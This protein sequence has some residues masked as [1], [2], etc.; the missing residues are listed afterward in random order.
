MMLIKLFLQRIEENWGHFTAWLAEVIDYIES[1]NFDQK[2]IDLFCPV[3]QE[4]LNKIFLHVIDPTY[5]E[6][7]DREKLLAIHRGENSGSQR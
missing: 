4:E 6:N 2:T 1:T 3:I 7:H 5:E